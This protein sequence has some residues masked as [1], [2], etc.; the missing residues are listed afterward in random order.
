[1][2][3]LLHFVFNIIIDWGHML[4]NISWYNINDVILHNMGNFVTI[5]EHKKCIDLPITV[6]KADNITIIVI[7]LRTLTWQWLDKN[8]C[9]LNKVHLHNVYLYLQIHLTVSICNHELDITMMLCLFNWANRNNNK[10]SGSIIC[11]QFYG[12][13]NYLWEAM[14]GNDCS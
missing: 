8:L 6:S 13:L 5:M 4:V 7:H 1:M 2:N 10:F 9:Y 12:L 14:P 11:L 3:N